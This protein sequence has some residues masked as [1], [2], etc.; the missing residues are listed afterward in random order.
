MNTKYV[1]AHKV[2]DE[3]VYFRYFSGYND[4]GCP[5]PDAKIIESTVKSGGNL[6][7]RKITIKTPSEVQSGRLSTFVLEITPEETLN[8][9]DAVKN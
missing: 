4:D 8:A 6:A 7:A 5:Q 3:D 9:S 1:V 2:D